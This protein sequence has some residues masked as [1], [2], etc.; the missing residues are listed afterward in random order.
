MLVPNPK[1]RLFDQIREVMRFHHYSL[2]TER[3]YCQWI[4]RYLGFHREADRSGPQRGWRHPKQMECLRLRV[5]DVEFARGHVVVREGKGDKDRVTVLPELPQERLRAH[6]E[7]LRRLHGGGPSEKGLPGVWL[8]EALAR[9]YPKA[10]EQW[11][12]QWFWPS[13][14]T[15][16]DPRTGLKRRHRV[17]CDVSAFC[18]AGSAEGEVGQEGDAA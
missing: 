9:K 8:P 15:M 16:T 11:E 17:G 5:K 1:G 7:R 18:A 4:Q 2:R 6:R 12:W 10:G 13:R 3:T 14:E